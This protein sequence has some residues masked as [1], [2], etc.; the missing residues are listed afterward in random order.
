MNLDSGRE[1]RDG[2]GDLVGDLEMGDVAA[3]VELD[4]PGVGPRGGQDAGDRTK[5]GRAL[6]SGDD[7]RGT[8]FDDLDAAPTRGLKPDR[9]E[10]ARAANFQED[11][12][13]STRNTARAVE[14]LRRERGSAAPTVS[15]RSS[16]FPVV[17][18]APGGQALHEDAD[19]PVARGSIF[20]RRRQVTG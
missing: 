1:S 4:E 11:G 7:Q 17:T 18:Q 12:E 5:P 13:V 6:A 8:A 3:A 15:G 20:R 10:C 2:C 14:T 19:A 9:E 16:S